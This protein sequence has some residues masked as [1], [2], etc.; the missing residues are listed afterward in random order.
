MA[1]SGQDSPYKEVHMKKSKATK[2]VVYIS[3][4]IF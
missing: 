2:P 3:T 1:Q 4:G